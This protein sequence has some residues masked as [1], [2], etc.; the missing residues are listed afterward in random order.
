MD[1]FLNAANL[2][3]GPAD[4]HLEFIS[5]LPGDV[6]LLPDIAEVHLEDVSRLPGAVGLLP[7]TAEVHLEDV[8]RLPDTVDRLL[9]A[10]DHLPDGQEF[11][12]T[13]RE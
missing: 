9:D 1:F 8:N 10:A 5:W 12:V 13:K 3:L 2:P 4:S 6:G 7:D 11:R